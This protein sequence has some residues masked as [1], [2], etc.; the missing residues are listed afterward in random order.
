M[1][2]GVVRKMLEVQLLEQQLVRHT[3]VVVAGQERH[4]VVVV[5]GL[6]RHIV[7]VGQ[8]HDVELVRVAGQ[9]LGRHIEELVQ[10][11]AVHKLAEVARSWL[12]VQLLGQ[13]EGL[14]RLVVGWLAGNHSHHQLQL[15]AR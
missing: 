2:A 4:I 9:L 6:V 15:P 5:V 10:E 8:E 7:V 12:V 13:L 11:R 3:V 14:H 1:T